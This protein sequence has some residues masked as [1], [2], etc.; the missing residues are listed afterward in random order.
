MAGLE[1][2]GDKLAPPETPQSAGLA[3]SPTALA[4]CTCDAWNHLVKVYVDENTDGEYDSGT[5]TLITLNEYDGLNR[6][7]KKHIDTDGPGRP[8]RRG[9]LPP[10]LLRGRH[11][12]ETHK[13]VNGL[14]GACGGPETAQAQPLTRRAGGLGGLTG[15]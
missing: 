13:A 11:I 10:L 1:D 3:T 7:V 9:H 14:R 12:I 15:R 6:R 8:R 4:L 2:K 5:D